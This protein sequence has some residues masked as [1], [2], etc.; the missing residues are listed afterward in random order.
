MFCASCSCKAA[1]SWE[2]FLALEKRADG[3]TIKEIGLGNLLFE[4]KRDVIIEF[5]Y[6][7]VVAENVV[8]K[9]SAN[10]LI[11]IVTLNRKPP[12]FILDPN[13][14]CGFKREED[15]VT[16]ESYIRC[17]DLP[18]RAFKALNS[19]FNHNR[20][21]YHSPIQIKQQIKIHACCT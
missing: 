20:L 7:G 15:P 1:G 19:H 21:P 12:A 4:K 6:D 3:M 8:P 17:L 14:T 2:Q 9:C 5:G 11:K 18:M 13:F 10:V 16:P